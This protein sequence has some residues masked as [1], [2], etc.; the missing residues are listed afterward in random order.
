M[1]F[2]SMRQSLHRECIYISLME[3][4][5]EE[6]DLYAGVE[7]RVITMKSAPLQSVAQNRLCPEVLPSLAIYHLL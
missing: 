7:T 3:E 5:N 6:P 4:E 1:Y 2:F